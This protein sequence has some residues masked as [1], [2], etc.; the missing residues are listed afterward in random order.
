MLGQSSGPGSWVL[1][2]GQSS[3]PAGSLGFLGLGQVGSHVSAW[4]AQTQRQ[5]QSPLPFTH[6]I[7]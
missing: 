7:T 6:H 1:G 3:G 2:L 4:P 5:T